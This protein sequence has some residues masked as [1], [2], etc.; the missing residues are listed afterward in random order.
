M[1]R[2]FL[3]YGGERQAERKWHP[4]IV[5]RNC[6]KRTSGSSELKPTELHC[7]RQLRNQTAG[8]SFAVVCT[9]SGVHFPGIPHASLSG[10]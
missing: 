3:I 1:A 5:V 2:A 9:K 10:F 6:A 4:G 7:S 8:G